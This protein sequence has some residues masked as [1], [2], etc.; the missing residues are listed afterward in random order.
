MYYYLFDMSFV[1]L[2][3]FVLSFYFM[4]NI[5]YLFLDPYISYTQI[6]MIEVCYI[7]EGCILNRIQWDFIIDDVEHELPLRQFLVWEMR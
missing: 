6:I 5:S 7:C 4:S 2:I 1:L 3:L